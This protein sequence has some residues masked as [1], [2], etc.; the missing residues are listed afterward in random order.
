MDLFRVRFVADYIV[1]YIVE[2]QDFKK[3]KPPS[4]FKATLHF[5][6][7]GIFFTS[8]ATSL[9]FICPI[10]FFVTNF[11]SPPHFRHFCSPEIFEAYLRVW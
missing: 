2:V 9:P 1:E 4:R 3:G 8:T 11:S 5:P 7:H 6:N 10:I